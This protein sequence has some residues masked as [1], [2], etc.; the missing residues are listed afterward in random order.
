MFHCYLRSPE[1]STSSGSSLGDYQ[2][3]W[4]S[5]KNPFGVVAADYILLIVH[6]HEIGFWMHDTK[7]Q[8]HQW[9]HSGAWN[10]RRSMFCCCSLPNRSTQPNRFMKFCSPKRIRSFCAILSEDSILI[11]MSVH[12][13]HGR[14]TGHS[15]PCIKMTNLPSL[16]LLKQ[17]WKF[18]SRNVRW[19]GERGQ[20]RKYICKWWNPTVSWHVSKTLHTS[21]KLIYVQ[22]FPTHIHG[23]VCI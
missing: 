22:T 15:G 19:V 20:D 4:T 23:C 16:V 11:R 8:P 7:N 12:H 14:P 2:Y 5:T 17:T 13:L 6:Q 10:C 18:A 1:A 9:E 21:K 3:E